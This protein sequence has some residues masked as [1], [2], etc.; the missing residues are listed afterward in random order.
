MNSGKPIYMQDENYHF[1]ICVSSIETHNKRWATEHG[2]L[3]SLQGDGDKEVEIVF[4]EEKSIL[5][6]MGRPEQRR[7]DK[8]LLYQHDKPNELTK[9]KGR[10]PFICTL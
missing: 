4:G 6:C 3:P 1:L 9:K 5:Y 2:C 10:T 7:R 8:N